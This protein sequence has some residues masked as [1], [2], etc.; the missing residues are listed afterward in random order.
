MS[1]ISSRKFYSLILDPLSKTD[2]VT[3]SRI[4]FYHAEEAT[5]A[6]KPVLGDLYH[7]DGRSFIGQLWQSF[8][9]LRYVEK[10][11]NAPGALRWAKN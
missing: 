1:T 6:I 2:R 11:P 4:P 8:T 5:E 9:T 10:D 7:H 3:N